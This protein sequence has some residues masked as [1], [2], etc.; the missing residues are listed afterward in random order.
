MEGGSGGELNEVMG[1]KKRTIIVLR[2]RFKTC[3]AY[4]RSEERNEGK[5]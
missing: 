1:R 2:D 4:M 5:K 3:D